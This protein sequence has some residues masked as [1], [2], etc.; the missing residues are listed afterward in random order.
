MYLKVDAF[1]VA[2]NKPSKN[3]WIGAFNKPSA[4]G[5]ETATAA[6]AVRCCE[7]PAYS[8]SNVSFHKYHDDTQQYLVQ[9]SRFFH[10]HQL[11]RG[12]W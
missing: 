10:D 1:A 9:Q 5:T 8:A 12:L 6:A 7:L 3:W 4:A 2:F 11:Q